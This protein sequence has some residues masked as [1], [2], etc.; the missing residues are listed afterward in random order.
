[1]RGALISMKN[2]EFLVKIA[3]V[4]GQNPKIFAPAARRGVRL[5]SDRIRESEIENER[6]LT[7][8]KSAEMACGAY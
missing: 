6:L 4:N 2:V 8:R 1:M 5:L 3:L 7:S